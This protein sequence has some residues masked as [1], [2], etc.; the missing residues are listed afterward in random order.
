MGEPW[1]EE[2]SQGW[3]QRWVEAGLCGSM[4]QRS[5]SPHP[6]KPSQELGL[7]GS[8]GK[9]PQ[10]L[11][12]MFS[13]PVAGRGCQGE[14]SDLWVSGHPTGGLGLSII[15]VTTITSIY[16]ALLAPAP[17]LHTRHVLAH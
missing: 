5:G 2:M 17:K 11:L 8:S 1:V 4:L 9:A 16:G 3:L 10:A 13:S 14:Q 6:L 12:S 7:Q 15:P